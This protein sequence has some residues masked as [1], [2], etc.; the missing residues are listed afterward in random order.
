MINQ[1]N[2]LIALREKSSMVGD[3]CVFVA[4][5]QGYL[6]S[7]I[8]VRASVRL[9][10]NIVTYENQAC[11]RADVGT[12]VI[13]LGKFGIVVGTSRPVGHPA[14]SQSPF[15]SMYLRLNMELKI[16]LDLQR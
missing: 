12:V 6:V 15:L 1:T 13:C 11:F 16:T 10:V 8:A 7:L 5:P 2:S 3:K 9:Y 4:F 14:R